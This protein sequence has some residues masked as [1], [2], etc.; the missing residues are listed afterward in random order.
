MR[1]CKKVVLSLVVAALL[2]PLGLLLPRLFRAGDAWG[3]WDTDDIARTLGYVPDGMARLAELWRAPIPDYSIW[4]DGSWLAASASYFVS[5][6]V[7]IILS[8]G[9]SYLVLRFIV[10][11]DGN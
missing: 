6:L 9:A 8:V 3:E 2:T 1:D 5:A 11:R 4:G 7:G 10:K